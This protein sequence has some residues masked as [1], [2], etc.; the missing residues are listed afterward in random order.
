MSNSNVDK[1]SSAY[2]EGYRDGYTSEDRDFISDFFHSLVPHSTDYIEGEAQG[3]RDRVRD[4]H[5]K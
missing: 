4:D 5:K 1:T 3:E 2:Q